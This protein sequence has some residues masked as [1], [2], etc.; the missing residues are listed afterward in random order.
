MRFVRLLNVRVASAASVAL[1][2]VVAGA[3][4]S[5]PSRPATADRAAERGMGED[6]RGIGVGAGAVGN[7][8]NHDYANGDEFPRAEVHDAVDANA[9]TAFARASYRRLQDSLNSQIRQMQFN[10][11]HSADMT[12][13]LK[14]EQQAWEDYVAARNAALKDVVND[15]KYQA[16]VT[17]KNE[18]GDRI[19]DAKADYAAV[20]VPSNKKAAA[21]ADRVKMRE[22]VTLALVKLDYAQVA[23]DMEVA[24]VRQDSK[25]ADARKRLMEAGT[26]V[27]AL[28]NDFDLKL[29]NSPE[30]AALRSKIDDARIAFITAESYRNGA[31]DAANEA[32]DYAYYKTRYQYYGGGYGNYGNGWGGYGIVQVR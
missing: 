16:S 23:T 31:V 32:L 24:A 1:G 30:L 12:D 17:M 8:D 7:H 2:L 25:V 21:A 4:L 6:L 18:M 9:R 3:A 28:R 29:R 20:P 22:I 27:Q 19:A 14:V 15:P 26:R 10:F 11:E 13:A 5:Q